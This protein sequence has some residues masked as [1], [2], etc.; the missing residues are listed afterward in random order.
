M[1][2][3]PRKG[4]E[5]TNNTAA[6]KKEKRKSRIPALNAMGYT[7]R[8]MDVK[9]AAKSSSD[10]HAI[11][12][13][14]YAYRHIW[15][16]IAA[17]STAFEIAG[18]TCETTEEYFRVKFNTKNT[19]SIISKVLGD[20][21]FNL[22]YYEFRKMFKN[23]TDAVHKE[24]DSI[25][26]FGSHIWDCAHVQ[27]SAILRKKDPLLKIPTNA[28]V[29]ENRARA[30]NAYGIG[31]PVMR[32]TSDAV[33]QTRIKGQP[34]P[35]LVGQTRH[36]A[37]LRAT[38]Q[39][40]Y[41][42]DL[43]MGSKIFTLVAYG[44]YEKKGSLELRKQDTGTLYLLKKLA[45]DPKWDFSTVTLNERDG[46]I[47][48]HMAYTR[49]ARRAK[50]IDQDRSAELHFGLI[51]NPKDGRNDFFHLRVET[52]DSKGTDRYRVQSVALDDI[53]SL[54]KTLDARKY[55][56]SVALSA[57]KKMRARSA[58]LT[59]RMNELTE[60]QHRLAIYR[61]NVSK[62]QNHIW[63]KTILNKII[64]W[65][66]GKLIIYGIPSGTEDARQNALDQKEQQSSPTS[67]NMAV[68]NEDQPT[69]GLCGYSWPW[70]KF[71]EY[72]VSVAMER[73]IE[74]VFKDGPSTS[75]M[76]ELILSSK[77]DEEDAK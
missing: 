10:Y 48:L 75:K 28:L 47:T 73:G 61:T 64:G 16:K 5:M 19:R 29:R 49:P 65:G 59:T 7:L 9:V 51:K 23:L 35:S 62:N 67:V 31:I 66:C 6:E 40:G 50:C 43:S 39:G 71:K 18:G 54:L 4:D 55:H 21:K 42:F 3:V 2:P 41:E 17:M 15:S 45:S 70:A 8:S 37:R 57:V 12:K 74:L 11:I 33:L 60:Q 22:P 53:L 68:E 1:G 34:D 30:P 52:L 20:V 26:E 24:D 25:P 69:V 32:W 14:I 36:Y 63:A 38:D 77:K 44:T 46:G 72:M 76:V 13:T 58:M 56:C 27:L